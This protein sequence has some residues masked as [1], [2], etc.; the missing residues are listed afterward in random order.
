MKHDRYFHTTISQKSQ[1]ILSL[2]SDLISPMFDKTTRIACTFQ[3]M[4]RK[5]YRGIQTSNKVVHHEHAPTHK[6]PKHL[7]IQPQTYACTHKQTNANV[8]DGTGI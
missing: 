6:G 5:T 1:S 2:L 4:N 8:S 3:C 7:N